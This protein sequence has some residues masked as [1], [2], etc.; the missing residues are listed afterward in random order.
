MRPAFCTL[1]WN[2]CVTY[3]RELLPRLAKTLLQLLVVRPPVEEEED[4]SHPEEDTKQQREVEETKRREEDTALRTRVLNRIK[5]L[6]TLARKWPWHD[7]DLFV[8]A[9]PGIQMYYPV[10]E[11]SNYFM[12]EME[13][14]VRSGNRKT[15]LSAVKSVCS[16]L[17]HNHCSKKRQEIFNKLVALSS[18]ASYYDRLHF[19][20]FCS[21]AI[22]HF[23]YAQLKE[24]RMFEC[25]LA[26]AED[27]V[28][29]L[30]LKFVNISLPIWKKARPLRDDLFDRINNMRN[31]KNKEVRLAA[32]QCY[33]YV[34]TH[35]AELRKCD[36][37][38]VEAEAAKE[39]REKDLVLL[40]IAV[41][42]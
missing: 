17:M 8:E 31:D 11:Y 41:L 23:S 1:F 34:Q 9:V 4:E 30:R 12:D 18:A 25:Y 3:A 32:D 38:L 27:R 14:L 28:A 40:E 24:I 42:L 39:K 2:P 22:E 6:W 21:V 10:D 20:V 33:S 7:L 37:A 13:S 19:L 5:E 35:E 36:D 16:L 29:N 15:R 26:L